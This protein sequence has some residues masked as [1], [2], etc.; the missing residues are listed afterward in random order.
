MNC[1]GALMELLESYAYILEKYYPLLLEGLKN[2]L[3][4]TGVSFVLGFMIGLPLALARIYG[5]RPLKWLATA[6]IELIR[7]T[8]MIVQL[9]IVYYALPQLGIVLSALA[10]AFLGMGINSGAYQAEYFRGAIRSIPSGQMEAALSLGMTRLQAIRYVILPQALRV[11]IPAWTN[12]LVYLLKYS[13]V[14][15]FLTVVELVYAGKIIGART[16]KYLE[17]YTI[18]ALIYLVFALAFMKISRRIEEKVAIP[19]LT[20]VKAR[21]L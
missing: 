7:G 1:S 14:A 19:G 20:M 9:F 21:F 16:F 3:L 5:P 2:T 17:V 6:F 18:I 8:P 13:S 11:V 4:L 15:Y 12:E 10:A